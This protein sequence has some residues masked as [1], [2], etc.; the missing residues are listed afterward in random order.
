MSTETPWIDTQWKPL[1]RLSKIDW[2]YWIKGQLRNHWNEFSDEQR[3]LMYINAESLVSDSMA[4]H[5]KHG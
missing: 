3:R 1:F 4:D 2:Q 5:Y